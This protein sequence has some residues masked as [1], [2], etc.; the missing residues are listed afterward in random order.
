[1]ALAGGLPS[2]VLGWCYTAETVIHL[3]YGV[4]REGWA[5]T[6]CSSHSWIYQECGPE[7]CR[8]SSESSA[9]FHHMLRHVIRQ[10]FAGKEQLLVLCEGGVPMHVG[11]F[12]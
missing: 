5:G 6:L 11:I 2:T 12:V 1:M 10:T 3:V 8:V 4:R 9:A 7:T